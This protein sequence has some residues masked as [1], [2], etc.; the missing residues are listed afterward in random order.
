MNK[1][2]KV[3]L[4]IGS[5]AIIAIVSIVVWRFLGKPYYRIG[6]I[7]TEYIENAEELAYA[8]EQLEDK[9]ILIKKYKHSKD[10]LLMGFGGGT[11]QT[12]DYFSY[13]IADKQKNVI[14]EPKYQFISSR[15]NSKR[16]PIVF[17]TPYAEKG[18]EKVMFYKIV[19]GKFHLISKEEASR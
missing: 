3:G 11:S 14:L 13:G 8:N 5:I 1:T 6:L 17:G 19:D 15:T 9:L 2:V 10:V 16:E 18:N 12:D 4:V 7:G